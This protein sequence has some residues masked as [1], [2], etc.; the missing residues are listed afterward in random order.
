MGNSRNEFNSKLL[1]L[2]VPLTLQFLFASSFMLI[3]SM[4]VAGLGEESIAAVG[5]AGQFEFLLG[6][7]LAGVL[8]GPSVFISQYYGERDYDSIKKLAA[9]TV[10]SGLAISIVF[11][12]LLTFGSP[13]IFAPFTGDQQLLNM[14]ATFV[15]IMSCGYVASAVTTA[16]V[17]SL[18]SIGVV[19]VI[20]YLTILSLCLNTF[21]NYVLIYG[22]LG[23]AAMGVYGAAAATM[24]S[25]LLLLSTTIV[26]VY[27]W[28]KEV[29]VSLKI[30]PRID[31][32]LIRSVFRITK[33]IIIHESLWGLGTTMYMV[34]FGMSGA[35]A[36]ALIQ[37]SK[38]I[39]NFVSAAISGFAQ[40]ASVMIGEQIGLQNREQAQN[41]A[42]RF[43]RIGCIL[44]IVIG[45]ALFISAP[46]VVRFFHISEQLHG[47]AIWILRIMSCV[48]I[49]NF[50]N[51]IWIVGV[52]R[53]GGDTQYSMKLVLSST[54]LVGIPLAFFGAG[55]MKWPIEV[56]YGLYA[57]EEIS[58]AIIGLWRYKSQRWQHNLI[59]SA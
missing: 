5:I 30:L 18:K 53:S 35:A 22:H 51:N 7:I 55:I 59:H 24:I 19:K 6:M 48:L 17:M 46:L 38:V 45:A 2:S 33:P 47:Q 40:S 57:T 9:L 31:R 42:E 15:S 41:Y 27:V 3:D 44:A 23:F 14:T 4:M 11:V 12:I 50:L 52:F 1:Q 49:C 56:V 13:F 26:Y 20:M 28:K 39:G 43:T 32:E 34:A 21:L 16:Y 10:F 8:S 25:K 37:I 36:I 58:K 54:W 29:A